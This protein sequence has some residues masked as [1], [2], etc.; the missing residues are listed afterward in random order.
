MEGDY[1][2]S[3]LEM[4]SHEVLRHNSNNKFYSWKKKYHHVKILCNPPVKIKI[5][6][7]EIYQILPVK[8]QDFPWRCPKK[9]VW[10]RISIRE[11]KSQKEQKMAFVG[12]YEFYVKNTKS[13]PTYSIFLAVPKAGTQPLPL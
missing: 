10:K 5:P 6:S 7:V 3:R 4:L 13:D 12:T 9:W 11:K 1:E 8:T 2:K